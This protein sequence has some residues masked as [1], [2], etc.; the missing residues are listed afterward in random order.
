MPPSVP[1]KLPLARLYLDDIVDI[2]EI[3]KGSD[4]DAETSF[5]V[6]G[7]RSD[8]LDDLKELGGNPKQFTMGVELLSRRSSAQLVIEE[9]TNRLDIYGSANEA[10]RW[11]KY[12]KVEAVFKKRKLK[13][14]DAFWEWVI[15]IL[16]WA[17]LPALLFNSHRAGLKTLGYML[18]VVVGLGAAPLLWRSGMVSLRYSH[19]AGAEKWLDAHKN[20]VIIGITCA[21]IGAAA[22]RFAELIWK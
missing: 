12:A 19:Q 8:T 4:Q 10:E 7:R 16:G 18:S 13:F 22:T 9:F 11:V 5:I 15:V 2:S 1:A 21:I 14:R 17:S 6:D 20:E 3:L